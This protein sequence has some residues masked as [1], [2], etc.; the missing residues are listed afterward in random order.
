VRKLLIASV[1][2]VAGGLPA[3]LSAGATSA[4]SAT[5]AVRVKVG[6]NYFVRA[7]GVPKLT[8]AKGTKVRWV[9]T[10]KRPHNVQAIRGPSRFG[11][12]TMT[13]GSYTKRLR[14]RGTYTI[15]CTIHSGDDQKMKLVVE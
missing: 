3:A 7:R 4:S 1:L 12:T 10:G 6:D 11:S 9:W 14:K 13:D 8:V 15:I 5:S 2:V